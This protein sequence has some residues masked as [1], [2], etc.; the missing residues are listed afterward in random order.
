MGREAAMWGWGSGRL[1]QET[2]RHI[3]SSSLPLLPLLG[4]A[5]PGVP[6]LPAP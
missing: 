1:N 6:V 4:P 3:L 2:G 5:L